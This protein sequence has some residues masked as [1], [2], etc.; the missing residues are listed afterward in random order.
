LNRPGGNLTGVTALSVE[1]GPKLL[2]LI[3]EMIPTASSITLVVN[4]A[5]RVVSDKPSRELQEMARTLGLTLHVLHASSEQEIEAIFPTLAQLG[6][7]ALIIGPETLFTS[8]SELLAALALRHGMP[9]IYQFREFTAAGGLMS[10]GID[11]ADAHRLTGVYVGRILN[12]KKPADLPVQQ[13]TIVELIINLKTAKAL[14][15]TV[16]MPLL[17]LA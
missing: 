9:A 10:Y 1:L 3:H 5:N 13:S 12:G 2:E 16:P 17:G 4:P 8:R 6:G 15:I 11:L 14:G 7:G